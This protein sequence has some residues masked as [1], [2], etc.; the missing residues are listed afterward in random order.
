M[1]TEGLGRQ[2]RYYLISALNISTSAKLQVGK[3]A[4]RVVIRTVKSNWFSGIITQGE[5]LTNVWL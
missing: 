1:I 4:C 2:I 5:N 3:V